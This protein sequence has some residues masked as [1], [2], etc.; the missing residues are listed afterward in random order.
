MSWPLLNLCLCTCSWAIRPKQKSHISLFPLQK[1]PFN[2]RALSLCDALAALTHF[3]PRLT[4][5]CG[6]SLYASYPSVGIAQQPGDSANWGSRDAGCEA[7]LCVWRGRKDAAVW[8]SDSLLLVTGFEDCVISEGL[9]WKLLCEH[10]QKS[11]LHCWL[12]TE[13]RVWLNVKMSIYLAL[14]Q[15]VYIVRGEGLL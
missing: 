3:P 4:Q 13:T 15:C 7:D 12:F 11:R 14:A 8:M 10:A 2:S 9:N 5:R 6:D 1:V